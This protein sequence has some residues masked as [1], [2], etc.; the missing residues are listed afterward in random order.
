MSQSRVIPL[1]G[2]HNFRRFGAYEAAGGATV[3]DRLFRSGQFS[4]ATDE[5]RETLGNLGVTTVADL[6]RPS[7]RQ[8]EPSHWPNIEG[9]R[10]IESDHAG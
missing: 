8:L 2:V 1:S 9:V 7:E 3:A 4:R 10:V 6:R 5:D